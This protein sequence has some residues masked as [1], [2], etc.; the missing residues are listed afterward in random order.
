MKG[1]PSKKA[2]SKSSALEEATSLAS[3]KQHRQHNIPKVIQWFLLLRVWLV[4]VFDIF[5]PY[6]L[7]MSKGSKEAQARHQSGFSFWEQTLQV[8]IGSP[9]SLWPLFL[10]LNKFKPT[11]I[12]FFIPWNK[13][14]LQVRIGRSSCRSKPLP[15]PVAHHPPKEGFDPQLY[16][17]QHPLVAKVPLAPFSRNVCG[18]AQTH[19]PCHIPNTHKH[20]KD[21]KRVLRYL[22]SNTTRS[23]SNKYWFFACLRHRP[24]RSSDQLL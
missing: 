7:W 6:F 16:I 8:P 10:G 4:G 17:M 1:K 5:F 22:A 20:L 3:K 9:R 18:L 12:R 11:K 19:I 21:P 23:G 15:Y 14:R 24:P 13:V 2:S